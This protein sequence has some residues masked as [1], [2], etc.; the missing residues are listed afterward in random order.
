VF[1]GVESRLYRDGQL[2][3]THTH[4]PGINTMGNSGYIGYAPGGWGNCGLNGGLDEVRLA[5]VA[6]SAGWIATEYANQK[7]PGEFYS[8]G[9]E[10]VV[11]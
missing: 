2:A 3:A 11:P 7:T 6:R 9:D 10:E 1:E 4:Q 8:V 5:T